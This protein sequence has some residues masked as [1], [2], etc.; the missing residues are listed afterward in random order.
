MKLNSFTCLTYHLSVNLKNLCRF[1]RK[2]SVTEDFVGYALADDV[3]F[4][5]IE[6]RNAQ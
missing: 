4:I 6:V 5:L 1:F 3:N 2:D